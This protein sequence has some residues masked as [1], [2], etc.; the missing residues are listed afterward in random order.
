MSRDPLMASV[1]S[2]VMAP[3]SV[4][5]WSPFLVVTRLARRRRVAGVS[6]VHAGAHWTT[7]ACVISPCT[8]SIEMYTTNV[9]ATLATWS[10]VP[11]SSAVG[12]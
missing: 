11:S 2:E 4:Q 10:L 12:P 1:V 9:R 3:L 5:R 7:C 6:R 8:R